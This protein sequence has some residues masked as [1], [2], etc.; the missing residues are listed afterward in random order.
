VIKTNLFKT[1]AIIPL[2]GISMLTPL[3]LTSCKQNVQHIDEGDD[4]DNEVQPEPE[5]TPQPEPNPTNN[6][7]NA[8]GTD[9]K[10]YESGSLVCG[11]YDSDSDEINDSVAIISNNDYIANDL[12]IPDYVRISEN[13]YPLKVICKE[14]FS[15]YYDSNSCN[16]SGN[17]IINDNMENIEDFAFELNRN[18]H[19]VS[20]PES[21]IHIGKFI[22][23]G[24]E[25]EGIIESSLKEITLLNFPSDL[26]IYAN[27]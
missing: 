11:A 23:S 9:W 20:V 13:V 8:D 5:P 1:F 18:L 6:I 4:S 26:T 7:G 22:F 2:L 10:G 12:V 27:N 25:E 24:K 17:L 16:I 14:A 15:N 19:S 21:L 3:V